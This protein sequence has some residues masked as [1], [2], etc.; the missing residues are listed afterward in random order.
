MCWALEIALESY[1]EEHAQEVWERNLM[2]PEMQTTL[3]NAHPPKLI[4][5]ILKAL[6]EQLKKNDQLRK[7]QAPVP[8][9]PVEY[10]Q[11]LKGGGR[12]APSL[13]A[14]RSYRRTQVKDGNG[15]KEDENQVGAWK[16]SDTN[17]TR[18]RQSTRLGNSSPWSSR[19]GYNDTTWSSKSAKS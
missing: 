12:F 5:T 9:I 18:L 7:L 6:R 3:L 10:D 11:I 4:A 13:G 19:H 16:T 2:N 8:E 15:G 17:Y 1:F 14:E